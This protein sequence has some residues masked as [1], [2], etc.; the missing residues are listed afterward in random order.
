M[1]VL[2]IAEN[3]IEGLAEDLRAS[4][5]SKDR[6]KNKSANRLAA[7][8]TPK[9]NI[10]NNGLSVNIQMEGY[11]KYVNAGRGA[12][13]VA[14]SAKIEDW[15]KRKGIDPRSKIEEW[16]EKRRAKI[17]KKKRVEVLKPISFKKAV[18]MMGYL[19]RRKLKNKGYEG[20]GFF[21]AVVTDQRIEGFRKAIAEE[22][23]I[24][25]DKDGNIE[26]NINK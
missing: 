23:D 1:G 21:D 8:I 18:D 24:D 20:N 19:V 22:L 5:E 12:G 2:N 7:S 25:F 14:E 17:V 11:W 10:L 15:I 3:F 26:F 6:S 13:G 16:K 4:L 9:V